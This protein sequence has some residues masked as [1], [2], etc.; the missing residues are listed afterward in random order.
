MKSFAVLG[1]WTTGQVSKPLL[2]HKVRTY[3]P[4][5]VL[6]FIIIQS[7]GFSLPR[8]RSGQEGG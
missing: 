1:T 2:E 7:S 3:F 8:G 5:I 4:H 6:F